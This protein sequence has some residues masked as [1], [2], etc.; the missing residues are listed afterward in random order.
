MAGPALSLCQSVQA[1]WL[2]ES[3][4]LTAGDREVA[5][6]MLMTKVSVHYANSNLAAA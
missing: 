4:S 1:A 2:A 6:L 3:T 5:R